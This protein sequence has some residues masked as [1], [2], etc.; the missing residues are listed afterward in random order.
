M[1]HKSDI[2]SAGTAINNQGD[3][4]TLST[5]SVAEFYIEPMLSCVGDVDIMVHSSCELAIPQGHPP[6]T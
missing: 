5:G 2:V 3:F 4:I 6:P 1:F